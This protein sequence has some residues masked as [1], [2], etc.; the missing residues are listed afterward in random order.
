MFSRRLPQSVE[1]RYAVDEHRK[2]QT[3]NFFLTHFDLSINFHNEKAVAVLCAVR[4]SNFSIKFD[5]SE[6]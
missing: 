2:F 5:R 1:H 3:F 4:N 6:K